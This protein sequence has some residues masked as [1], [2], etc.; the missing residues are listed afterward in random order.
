M[1]YYTGGALTLA[2]I[3]EECSTAS[4]D[5]ANSSGAMEIEEEEAEA[6][7][8]SVTSLEAQRAWR[9]VRQ[10]VEKNA[11]NPAVLCL[12]DG[13]DDFLYQERHKKQKQSTLADFFS[14]SH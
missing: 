2:E 8:P 12:S 5:G 11:N 1:L 13:L 4:A 14:S 9:I 6:E 3:V 10:Y 7:D